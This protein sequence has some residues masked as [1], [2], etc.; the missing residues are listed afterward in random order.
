TRGGFKRDDLYLDAN[1]T[2]PT[3]GGTDC[4]HSL[5][6]LSND[7]FTGRW[8]DDQVDIPTWDDLGSPD[9]AAAITIFMIY[10][11]IPN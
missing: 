2:T 8:D 4:W 10:Y 3:M 6:A 11:E 1:L 7:M 9:A 5:A